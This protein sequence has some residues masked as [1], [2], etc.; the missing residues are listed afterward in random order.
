MS[1]QVSYREYGLTLSL[2]VDSP[3]P[4]LVERIE[5]PGWRRLPFS[6]EAPT[7]VVSH[8]PNSQDPHEARLGERLVVANREESRFVS[9]LQTEIYGYLA[10]HSSSHAFIHA[11]AVA[12]DEK[13][14]LFPGH[15]HAGKSTFVRAL[16]EAG[17]TYFS[18]E[19]GVIEIAT[20][21]IFPFPRKV[22]LR[23]PERAVQLPPPSDDVLRRGLAAGGIILLSYQAEAGLELEP[24]P[25]PRAALELFSRSVAARRLG[26]KL[27]QAYAPVVQAAPCWRGV[28]GEA[29]AAARQFLEFVGGSQPTG[30]F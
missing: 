6:P 1:H 8:N 4:G 9:N 13:A 21:R 18:D 28:R 22:M 15:S 3:I 5:L 12:V 23:E 30:S 17:A 25:P 20:G 24:C 16:V 2:S 19:F 11:G 14:F 29:A 27:L 26:A 7:Y 10:E